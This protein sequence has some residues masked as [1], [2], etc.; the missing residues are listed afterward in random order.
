MMAEAELVLTDI[1]AGK[2]ILN[3]S[4]SYD[5]VAT[6]EVKIEVNATEILGVSVPANKKW[7]LHITLRV[8]E[9]DA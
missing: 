1:Y 4:A 2:K 9:E 8:L 7:N 5:L 6:Q 3:A